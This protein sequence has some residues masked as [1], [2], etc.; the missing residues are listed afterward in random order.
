MHG[1]G[2]PNRDFTFVADAVAANLRAEAPADR[3]AGRAYNIARGRPASL[4]EL[5][6]V[7]A[8]ELGVSVTPVHTDPRPG[9]VR[10]SHA[11]ISA[12]RRDL[13]YAPAVTFREGL[14]RTLAWFRERAQATQEKIS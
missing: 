2:P 13:G 1:D 10:H 8:G 12:A 4:L 14:A 11:D 9:D 3:C 5:L 7:L 6:D